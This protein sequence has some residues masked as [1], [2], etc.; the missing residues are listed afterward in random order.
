VDAALPVDLRDDLV[1]PRTIRS[2]WT[3]VI[4]ASREIAA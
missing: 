4:Q 3:P 2:A 1:L